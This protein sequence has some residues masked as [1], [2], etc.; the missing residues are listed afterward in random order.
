MIWDAISNNTIE[1]AV[2]GNTLNT[3]VASVTDGFEATG[4]DLKVLYDKMENMESLLI[5][6]TMHSREGDGKENCDPLF[7]APLPDCHVTPKK[8]GAIIGKFGDWALT[9]LEMQRQDTL[10][11]YD[12]DVFQTRKHGNPRQILI[13]T[14]NKGSPNLLSPYSYSAL[15][16]LPVTPGSTVRMQRISSHEFRSV[17]PP[18]TYHL[19]EDGIEN[20]SVPPPPAYLLAEDG[21]ENQSVPPPPAHLL[22][23]DE[24]LSPKDLLCGT[25]FARVSA[26]R[27]RPP[28]RRG[29]RKQPD[30]QKNE[31]EPGSGGDKGS[32]R[33]AGGGLGGGSGG[34]PGGKGNGSDEDGDKK[35]EDKEAEDEE[36]DEDNK[37][38]DEEEEKEESD[39]EEKEESDGEEKEESDGNL[40]N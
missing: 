29:G 26:G 39:G 23:E 36:E 34:P 4:R 17:L 38:S 3:V 19:A 15:K 35:E 2:N 32:E 14:P 28:K 22:T 20:Q 1:L 33:A 24:S 31:K 6:S 10:P 18:P 37:E 16:N 12:T 21:I 9:Q 13:S 5:S 30:R 27:G 11:Y 25:G 7:T 40:G 8:D